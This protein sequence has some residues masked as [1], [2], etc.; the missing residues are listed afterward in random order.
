MSTRRVGPEALALLVV[1][2][3][4]GASTAD[5]GARI[6]FHSVNAAG[7]GFEDPTPVDPVGGNTGTTL[8]EQ[9]RIAFE[10]ALDRWAALISSDVEIVVQATF[11]PLFCVPFGG[12]LGSAAPIGIYAE[13]P[14]APREATWYPSPLANRLAGIDL[15]PGPF[16]PGFLEPP[17]NDDVFAI[18]NASL[19]SD[20]NCLGGVG[21]YYGLDDQHGDAVDLME[22][23]V[24]ELAHG[25]GF[26]NFIDEQT[27]TAFLGLDDVYGSHTFDTFYGKSWNDLAPSQRVISA[28]RTGRL[29]WNGPHV[30]AQ[31]PRELDRRPSL[32]VLAPPS[33]ASEIEVQEATFGPD[34]ATMPIHGP[35]VLADDGSGM[36]T[37]A[38]QPLIGDYTG[39]VV[40]IDRGTCS[41]SSKTAA[42]Q[43]V[44]AVGVL[45]ANITPDGF[46]PMG[47]DDP[48]IEI[49]AVGI[50]QADGQRIRSALPGVTVEVR[51]SDTWL[52]GADTAGNV[53]LY[54][55][56]PVRPGSS[57]A[58]FDQ[59][60]FPPLLMQPFLVGAT[61]PLESVDLTSRLLADLGWDAC[62]DSDFGETVR[63]GPCDSGVENLL[64]DTGCTI[65]DLVRSC[66]AGSTHGRYVRCVA[67]QLGQM[68][69]AGVID[70]DDQGKIQSCAARRKRGAAN[71][72]SRP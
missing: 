21:W 22:V 46:P 58:H 15:S 32:T 54:A 68:K 69:R 3:T 25:L 6:V 70:G 26:Q 55:P 30:L 9:R 43:A 5:A 31:A 65:A 20:P 35:V 8:G 53:R 64:F 60:A 66:E 72:G 45:V 36:P 67:S 1:A 61:N 56:N 59:S 50:L 23:L 49:P 18:L 12:L 41:F 34:V 13:F 71:P 51:L 39:A 14:G 63:I 62:A 19:D 29:V 17:F 24:H 4:W 47:G 48:S 38:C 27:G 57:V 44:G 40:L 2:W 42:A 7:T 16:D 11:E 37:D 52:E 28:R 33:V 10:V